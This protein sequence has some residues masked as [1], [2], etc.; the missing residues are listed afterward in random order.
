MIPKILHFTWKTKDIPEQWQN[1]FEKWKNYHPTWQIKLWTDEDNLRLVRK[2]VPWFYNIY[3]KLPFP[4]NRADCAR[5]IYMLKFGGVYVD[6]DTYPIKPLDPLLQYVSNF[7][8]PIAMGQDFASQSQ[9]EIAFIMSSKGHNFFFYL[10]TH[11]KPYLNGWK[12]LTSFFPGWSVLM[13]SGPYFVY[14]CYNE[15]RAYYEATFTIK[16]VQVNP[17]QRSRTDD[18]YLVH[19]NN[20]TWLNHSFDKFN[21]KIYHMLRSLGFDSTCLLFTVLIFLG[22]IFGALYIIYITTR[23]TYLFAHNRYLR[24]S[25]NLTSLFDTT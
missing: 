23:L 10:L 12:S 11:V 6:L 19:L 5:Y 18:L 7:P 16:S 20:A 13:L 14:K 22:C 1:N 24:R 21:H 3:K 2:C 8:T 15:Y 25:P 17:Y 4:I 9:F